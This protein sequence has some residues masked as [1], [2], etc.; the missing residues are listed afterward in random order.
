M[1]GLPTLLRERETKCIFLA[2]VDR[3]ARGCLQALPLDKS[4]DYS[5]AMKCLSATNPPS[6][7]GKNRHLLIRTPYLPRSTG[8]Y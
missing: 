6:L 7:A 2:Q 8:G 4:N 5:Y 3:V 1:A